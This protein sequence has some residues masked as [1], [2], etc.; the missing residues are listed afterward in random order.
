MVSSEDVKVGAFV[1]AGLTAIGAV[2]FLIGDERQLFE[3]KLAYT[4]ELKTFRG[5]AAAHPCAWAVWT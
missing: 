1:L 4:T 5:C 3:K 2:I